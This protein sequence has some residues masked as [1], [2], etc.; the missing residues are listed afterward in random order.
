MTLAFSPSLSKSIFVG[1]EEQIEIFHSILRGESA[2]WILHIPGD[3]GIGKTRLLEQYE[4]ISHAEYGDSLAATGIIDFYDTSNQTNFGLLDELAIRLKFDPQGPFQREIRDLYEDAELSGA[5]HQ[6]RFEHAYE[7]FLDEY[8]EVLNSRKKV[9]I[10]F[11]TCEEMRGVEEWI[12]ENLLNDIDRLEREMAEGREEWRHKTVIVFAGRKEMDL[13]KFGGAVWTR[14]LPL[15]GLNEIKQYFSTNFDLTVSIEE[16][17]FQQIYERTA[18]RPLYVALVYDWLANNVGS[19]DE[20]LDSPGSFAAELVGWV[21][22]LETH[23]KMAILFMAFAW[24]RM[25]A[26]LLSV[27]LGLSIDEVKPLLDELMRFSF[28]KYREIEDGRLIVN[29]HDEMRKLVNDHVWPA[30]NSDEKEKP[31]DLVLDWYQ[32]EID[33][34][35]L[36]EGGYIPKNDRER[37][38]LAEELYYRLRLDLNNGL[39]YYETRFIT[40]VHYNELAYCEL[41]NREVDGVKNSISKRERDNYDFRVALTAFRRDDY[42]K[43]G[44]IWHAFV[45]RPNVEP[46]LRATTLMLLVEL[47]SYTGNPKEAIKHAKEAES[48]YQRLINKTS[49]GSERTHL[50]KQLGQ[51]YNNW[52]YA[53]RVRDEYDKSLLYYKKALKIP[54]KAL[55]AKKHKARVLNNMGYI[56]FLLG[57]ME[58]AKTFIGRGLNIRRTLDIPYELGLSYNTFG[59]IME[60]GGRIPV[61]VDLFTK[62]YQAFEA[63]HSNRGQAL[64]RISLGRMKRFMN[65]FDA[66][67]AEL[68]DAERTFQRLRDR[69]YLIVVKNEIGS[70]YREKG[71]FPN[72]LKYLNESLQLSLDLGKKHQQADT[73]DDIAVTYYKMAMQTTGKEQKE[74]LKKG[75]AHAARSQKLA[76]AEGID[77]FIAKADIALGDIAYLQREYNTAFK[78]YF[79]ATS[80]M[81]TAWA[82]RNKASGFY[83]RRYEESLDRMQERLH[84]FEGA[85]GIDKTLI[86]VKRLLAKI[87][88]LPPAE[89]A[90]L[91]KT[92][93]TLKATLETTSLTK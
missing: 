37:A 33:N 70:T 73:L 56:Y 57:D 41:L 58:R 89:K 61:A 60:D 12:L 64:A 71:V 35:K 90:A 54:A 76:Q 8:R 31:Y 53:Y 4:K 51:V 80:R 52:G 77:F 14:R 46:A 22:R 13:T 47:D 18:G 78:H 21:R 32:R 17:K 67:L 81:A 84:I 83:Q 55:E 44:G 10:L 91:S 69:D 9:L 38:L 85:E 49:P 88:R 48:I 1:R 24:R 72:A 39:K 23:K 93:K 40:A 3:G 5:D 50:Q 28:I 16:E 15:L 59:L 65:D 6:D 19:L 25:E 75:G 45:R 7:K 26:S 63:A 43:A 20:L 27:L 92:R 74:N 79:E 34:Q 11:D 29:L 2:E 62:A 36:L 42:T 87:D 68:F 86:Y 30:E 66:A 82:S